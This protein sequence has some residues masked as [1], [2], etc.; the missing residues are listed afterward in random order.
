MQQH[1]V[2]MP[3]IIVHPMIGYPIYSYQV[4]FQ[5]VLQILRTLYTILQEFAGF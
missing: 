2:L 5:I 4:S 3:M 1:N